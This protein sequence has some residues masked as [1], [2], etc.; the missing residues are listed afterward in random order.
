MKP[1]KNKGWRKLGIIDI[2]HTSPPPRVLKDFHL[3]QNMV[4]FV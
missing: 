4:Q 2:K 3:A 1:K